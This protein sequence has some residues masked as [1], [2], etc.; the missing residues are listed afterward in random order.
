[1]W[2]GIGMIETRSGDRSIWSRHEMKYLISES[3]ASGITQ[4]VKAY[5]CLDRHSEFKPNNAYMINS[6]YLDSGNMSLCR[7]SLDG[8]R[9][10]FKLRIRSYTD[11]VD[12]PRFF[13][14][15]RRQ[16]ATIKRGIFMEA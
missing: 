7:E 14:I 15:K 11:D 13:E 12:Y 6:V 10:R 16:S 2:C 4:Y 3:T 9:N 1:M 8:N 5:T